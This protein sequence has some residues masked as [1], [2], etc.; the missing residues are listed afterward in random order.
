MRAAFQ[1]LL[2]FSLAAALTLAACQPAGAAM[3]AQATDA[4]LE[5]PT[6][7]ML[8]KQTDVMLEK[9]TEAM[10]DT[11][12]GA[13]MDS[14]IPEAM[15]DRTPE[16][17]GEATPPAEAM[18]K[19]A[20]AWLGAA[21]TEVTTGETFA[22]SSLKGKVVLVEAMA[23]WCSKCLQQQRNVKALH[24]LLGERDDFVSLGLD[25]DPNESAAVL[26]D[27]VAAQGFAW[28]Y[29]VAPAEVARELAALYGD[30]FLNPP[31][32]PMLIID[33][34]GAVHPLPFGIKSADDL[35]KALGPFLN[36]AM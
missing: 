15:L 34:H 36:E 29:A 28:R 7:V 27:Y 23:V 32:T 20:P 12:S 10:M 14:H 4:V 31:S 11:P 5:K 17:M 8:E 30:Q 33:R 1:R 9:P 24:G 6:D 3:P 2:T 22:V 16:A 21:L 13:A 26:R 25:I 35:Q 19:E 18:P